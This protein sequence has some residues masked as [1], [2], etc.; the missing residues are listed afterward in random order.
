MQTADHV[1][2]GDPKG[3]RLP[4]SADNFVNRI[5]EGV[6]ITL[7]RRKRAELAGKDADVRV[8][9]VTI[10]DVRCVVA[11]FSFAQNVGDHSQRVE[12]VRAVEGD[13]IG[14]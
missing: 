8:I 11:V 3:Q 7:F 5:F 1:D 6:R 9:N 10:V 13:R 14:V 2:F 12:V 4:D